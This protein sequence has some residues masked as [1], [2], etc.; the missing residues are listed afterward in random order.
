MTSSWD[1]KRQDK[2]GAGLLSL[3]LVIVSISLA[4]SVVIAIVGPGVFSRNTRDTMERAHRIR[5]ALNRYAQHNAGSYPAN[6]TLLASGDSTTCALVNNPASPYHGTLQGWCGPYLFS[7]FSENPDGYRKDGWGTI[8]A[9]PGGG[10]TIQSAGP[11]R[12]WGT[13]DDLS[14]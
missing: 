1:S 2:T 4:A 14:F 5:S 8:F 7:E 3:L 9:Y 6:L 10:P 11:D 13:S 12:Q